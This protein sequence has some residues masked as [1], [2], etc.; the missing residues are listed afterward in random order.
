M[1][2]KLDTMDFLTKTRGHRGL[3][4]NFAWRLELFGGFQILGLNLR[5]R[6]R[7]QPQC[8]VSRATGSRFHPDLAAIR[9]SNQPTKAQP[10]PVAEAGWLGR[11]KRLEYL[12]E[13]VVSDARPRVGDVDL[14]TRLE[15]KRVRRV[16]VSPSEQASIAL[17]NRWKTISFTSA[18]VQ[19]TPGSSGARSTSKLTPP[20]R[21][22]CGKSQWSARFQHSILVH[23]S[24]PQLAGPYR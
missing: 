13:E 17:P 6:H 12:V 20:P 2:H 21:P 7:G 3:K 19:V 11:E 16:T 1:Y 22:G 15:R 24:G 14:H 23:G 8:E 4:S 9:F 5:C 18:G 10:N